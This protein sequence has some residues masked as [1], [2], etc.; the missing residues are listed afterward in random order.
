VL[1]V[2]HEKALEYVSLD[3]LKKNALNVN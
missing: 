2:T 1:L 3:E